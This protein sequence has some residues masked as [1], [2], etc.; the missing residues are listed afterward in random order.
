M[1]IRRRDFRTWHEA[2]IGRCAREADVPGT[3]ILTDVA[4]EQPIADLG[5][6]RV[7][8]LAAMLDRQIRNARSRVEIARSDEG[9]G[10]TGIEAAAAC[11]AAVRFEGEIRFQRCIGQDDA[12]ER[13]RP[14]LWM[15]QHHVLPNP[16]EARELCELALG[17]W[18]GIDVATRG[19]PGHDFTNCRGELLETVAEDVVVVSGP[20]VLGDSTP[21]HW[22]GVSRA[23]VVVRQ[24]HNG[25][26][27][28]WHDAPRIFPLL[29]LPMQIRHRAGMSGRQPAIE[30]GGVWILLEPCDTG[31]RKAQRR[32]PPFD[33]DAHRPIVSRRQRAKLTTSSTGGTACSSPYAVN[34][35]HCMYSRGGSGRNGGRCHQSRARKLHASR[36]KSTASRGRTNAF[37]ANRT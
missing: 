33:L 30:L 15:D 14:E 19:R 7:G 26:T 20:R 11:P 23:V 31:G 28:P 5:S 10:R 22:A 36:T 18:T 37:S 8:E 25:G 9:I 6:L 32:R 17:N 12:D 35:R 4:T 24:S 1:G 3:D 16:S 21:S 13:E 34:I 2:G 29:R 27:S